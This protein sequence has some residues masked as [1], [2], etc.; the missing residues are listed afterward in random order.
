MQPWTD[1][2]FLRPIG[3]RSCVVRLAQTGA[4]MQI[5]LQDSLD[6]TRACM[7]CP[8]R[9]IQARVRLAK[10]TTQDPCELDVTWPASI[11]VMPP[12][13]RFTRRSN[14]APRPVKRR[15]PS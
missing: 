15:K 11:A 4:I 10:D 6:I 13:I 5:T 12:P 8:T 7:A 2:H 1:C 14:A 3:S 9:P